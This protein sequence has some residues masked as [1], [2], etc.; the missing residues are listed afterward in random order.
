MWYNYAFGFGI[1]PLIAIIAV[2]WA[3]KALPPPGKDSEKQPPK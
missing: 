3:W 1:L 2:I